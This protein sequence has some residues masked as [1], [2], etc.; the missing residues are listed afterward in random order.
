M[1]LL[2]LQI[3]QN[4]DQLKANLING[5]PVAFGFVVYESF[6]SEEVAK[7]GFVPMPQ[8]NEKVLGG[9]A[10]AMVGFDDTKKLFIVRNSWGN[11]WGD[12]GYFYMPYDYVLNKELADDFWTIKKTVDK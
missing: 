1:I 12:K 2:N 7:T 8:P 9:H 6:E 11:T 10:V 3:N 5:Y 4:L